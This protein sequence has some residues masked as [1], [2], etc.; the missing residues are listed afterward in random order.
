MADEPNDQITSA[1]GRPPFP[2]PELPSLSAI[3]EL[4]TTS[5]IAFAVGSVDG[6][7]IYFNPA[8]ERLTG[9]SCQDLSSLDWSVD[10]TPHEWRERE[11]AILSRLVESGEPVVYE[12]EYVRKDGTRVPIELVVHVNYGPDGRAAYFYSFLTDLTTRR[13]SETALERRQIQSDALNRVLITIN[14]SMDPHGV[15]ESVVRESLAVT[16]ADYS[17]IVEL[18]DDWW[19]VSHAFGTGG[20]IR[21]G[22][23]YRYAERP[24]ILDAYESGEIQVVNDSMTNPRTNKTIMARYEVGAF[25]AVP[26]VLRD[27][28]LGVLE[29]VRSGD[30][31][32]FDP[33]ELE[34]LENIARAVSVSID[35]MI[36]SER[37]HVVADTLQRALLDIPDQ[38]PGVLITSRYRAATEHTLV[39]GDLFDVFERPDGMIEMAIGD[40]SGK[41]P[42]AASLTAMVR[43]VL[44]SCAL[45]G[46]DVEATTRKINMVLCYFTPVEMFTT[47]FVAQ[48]DPATGD[49]RYVNGGH[50]AP[51][52]RRAD[53]SVEHLSGADPIVGAFT[54]I[55]FHEHRAQLREGDTL[56][57]ITD[58]VI[59]ARRGRELYGDDGL[60][61]LLLS[62][63][64]A[65]PDDVLDGL[66]ASLET[67]SEGHLR[68]DV[69]M[70][71]ITWA[72]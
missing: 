65:D 54:E 44:R 37:D 50:P 70:M 63:A 49:L 20:D 6:R 8:F 55:G 35:R 9:Y 61:A 23:R 28:T 24:V 46:L 47:L 14:S 71:A 60:D 7:I 59:E 51:R 12:K 22:P 32:P 5:H 15:L 57:M 67:F 34:F 26:L 58:G 10:L 4:L 42:R 31:R 48:L 53:G 25:V 69:A 2:V 1:I 72:R 11:A 43:D 13:L 45:D 21:V 38:V 62:C 33:D 3:G 64:S 40:V 16:G 29:I 19:V 39:G 30:A 36:E 68:D 41:G 52:V 27:R 18:K 56:F 66:L 17:L